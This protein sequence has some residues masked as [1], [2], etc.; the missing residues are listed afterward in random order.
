MDWGYVRISKLFFLF[1][2]LGCRKP[3]AGE[4]SIQ[5][6]RNQGIISGTAEALPLDLNSLSSVRQFAQTILN[7]NIPIDLLINNAG[8]MFQPYEVTMDGHESQFQTNYL[9]HFLL[10]TLLQPA[11]HQGGK[12]NAPSRVINLSSAAQYGGHVDF[13]NIDT[14]YGRTTK[15]I[16]T[17]ITVHC[18]M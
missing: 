11:L 4:S 14:K 6:L 7:K 12:P 5:S 1:K 18:K 3:A 17:V 8:V 15:N 10:T 2:F 9:S 16:Q 13:E